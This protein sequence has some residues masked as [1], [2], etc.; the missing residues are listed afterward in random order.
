MESTETNYRRVLLKLNGEIF[1]ARD[2]LDD[3]I[4][5]FLLLKPEG[6]KIAILVGGGNI[7][8][9]KELKEIDRVTA[10]RMGMLATVINGMRLYELLKNKGID[11]EHYSAIPIPWVKFYNPH[12]VRTD[13]ENK[14]VVLSGGTSNPYFTT[15]TAAVLRS[16]EIGAEILIKGTKVEGVYEE[17]PLKHPEAKF[18]KEI[19]Y[20]YAIDKGLEIMDK[21]AFALAHEYGIV[22]LV[23]NIYK[24][25][26][27]IKALKEGNIGTI[28]K[29]GGKDG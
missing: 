29:K 5:S 12:E 20:R 3:L 10:D 4:D 16:M 26:N 13:Y 1:K 6:F 23:I 11:C 15:D 24:K 17:D 18:L 2:C 28:I 19:D 7:V 22:I 25:G 8:R 14:I 9:G 21:T 27:F